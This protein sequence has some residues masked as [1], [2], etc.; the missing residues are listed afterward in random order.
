MGPPGGAPA[1]LKLVLG[2]VAASGC[3]AQRS[4]TTSVCMD[5]DSAAAITQYTPD[6]M[7][8]Q[9]LM[10][11]YQNGI[12]DSMGLSAS[13]VVVHGTQPLFPGASVSSLS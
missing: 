4:G 8:Y 12:A 2:V 3:S 1:T 6:S 9:M 11:R 7:E 5:Q 13:D 10:M